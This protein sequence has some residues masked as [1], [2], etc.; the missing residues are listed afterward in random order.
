M[1]PDLKIIGGVL[2]G[3]L[4]MGCVSSGTYEAKVS[5]LEKSQRELAEARRA[6]LDKQSQLDAAEARV[7]A[8]SIGEQNLKVQLAQARHHLEQ[9]VRPRLRDDEAETQLRQA[10]GALLGDGKV[11]L[12]R[13]QGR[14]VLRIPERTLFASPQSRAIRKEA[15]PVLRAVVEA[16][17]ATGRTY[18]VAGHSNELAVRPG[19]PAPRDLSWSRA[20]TVTRFFE[21]NGLDPW[22]VFPAAHGGYTPISGDHTKEALESNRRIEVLLLPFKLVEQM[23]ERVFQRDGQAAPAPAQ[24][25]RQGRGPDG[26]MRRGGGVNARPRAVSPP[27]AAAPSPAAPPR[28]GKP[29]SGGGGFEGGGGL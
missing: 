10:L 18:R 29:K 17:K 22:H 23:P 9:L 14:P 3:A 8:L 19:Q 21:Q 13:F 1:R 16:L 27:P 25:L 28:S 2:V 4:A 20:L 11:Q 26:L 6:Q 7:R 15:I 5:L 24:P 12:V